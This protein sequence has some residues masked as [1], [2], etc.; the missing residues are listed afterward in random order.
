MSTRYQVFSHHSLTLDLPERD[1]PSGWSI[2][3]DGEFTAILT[4]SPSPLTRYRGLLFDIP[5]H[6]VF[7]GGIE[8]STTN[9][10][11]LEVSVGFLHLWDDG[12]RFTTWRDHHLR[13]PGGDIATAPP[14]P[15]SSISSVRRGTITDDDGIPL[16][17]DEARMR[18]RSLRIGLILRIRA[19][20]DDT[21]TTRAAETLDVVRLVDRASI[22]FWQLRATL[23]P[24]PAT[25]PVTPRTDTVNDAGVGAS[26][27]LLLVQRSLVRRF[28]EFAAGEDGIEEAFRRYGLEVPVPAPDPRLYDEPRAGSPAFFRLGDASVTVE[29][30]SGTLIWTIDQELEAHVDPVRGRASA[31]AMGDVIERA[32]R[33]RSPEVDPEDAPHSGIG[34]YL[35]PWLAL[36]SLSLPEDGAFDGLIPP[37]RVTDMTQTGSRIGYSEAGLTYQVITTWNIVAESL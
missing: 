33:P 10:A 12:V 32:F 29:T 6:T 11:T 4:L 37:I 2:P 13:T 8:V 5:F 26:G 17:V 27:V 20:S 35:E 31:L 15:F 1:V 28:S 23:D 3:V 25:P 16:V 7:A 21:L 9:R 18:D 34:L 19:F 22:T 30:L 36:G 24:P 14:A